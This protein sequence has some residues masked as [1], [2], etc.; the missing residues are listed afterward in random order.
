MPTNLAR[1]ILDSVCKLNNWGLWSLEHHFSSLGRHSGPYGP[2]WRPSDSKWP[3][4]AHNP[5]IYNFHTSSRIF[6]TRNVG[7]NQVNNQSWST[8][9]CGE[10][11]IRYILMFHC[12]SPYP[13]CPS[14]FDKENHCTGALLKL[15]H[16]LHTKSQVLHN[17][18]Y[19]QLRNCITTTHWI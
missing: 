5:Q 18:W 1:S 19:A 10:K 6:R 9:F 7:T 12:W 14:W 2:S 17:C 11:D 3:S 16:F 13:I 8:L 4:S 15:I